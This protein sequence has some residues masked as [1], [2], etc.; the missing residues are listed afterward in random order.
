[1][2][3]GDEIITAINIVLNDKTID[4]ST[5]LER[6]EAYI[7]VYISNNSPSMGDMV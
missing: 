3:K 7:E 4:D 5:K 1:L 2:D 6:I